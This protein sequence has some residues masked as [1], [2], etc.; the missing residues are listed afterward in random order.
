MSLGV[1]NRGCGERQAG[2]Q[3]PMH[4]NTLDGALREAPRPFEW[5]LSGSPGLTGAEP[6]YRVFRKPSFHI[7][8]E[9]DSVL[10]PIDV[11]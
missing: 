8:T 4:H 3:E 6:G 9:A 1:R 7:L 10:T 2:E 11:D 5:N